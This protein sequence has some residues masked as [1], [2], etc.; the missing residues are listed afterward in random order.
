MSGD[1]AVLFHGG[2]IHTMDGA[3]TVAEAILVDGGRIVAT[4]MHW[5]DIGSHAPGHHA[6][7]AIVDRDPIDCPLEELR[8]TRVLRTV[9]AGRAVYDAGVLAG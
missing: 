5:P 7:L 2:R 9:F 1:Q 8:D 3:D 4:V 6:D